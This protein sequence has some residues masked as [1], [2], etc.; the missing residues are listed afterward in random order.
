MHHRKTAFRSAVMLMLAVLTVAA[1]AACGGSSSSSANPNTLLKDTFTGKHTVTSGDIDLTLTIDPSGSSLVNGPITF[2]FG[3][4]FQSRGA[5]KLP[6]SNFTVSASALGH[7]VLVG[8]ISTG[9]AGYVTFQGSSYQLP[10]ASFQKLES[11][12]SQLSTSQGTSS[13]SS[14]LTKLGIHPLNWLTNPTVV[15]TENVGGAQTDHIHAGVN[16]DAMLNDLST[17]LTKSYSLGLAGGTAAKAL[18]GGIPAA[19]RSKIAAEVKNPSVDIW[20]GTSDHT[21]RRLTITLTVPVTGKTSTQLGGVTSADIGL[22]LQ[23]SDLNQP[24]TIKAPTNVKPFSQ[25]QA[26]L[27][28]FVQSL[29]GLMAAGGTGSSGAGTSGGTTTTGS[30]SAGVSRYSQCLQKAGTDIQKV[31]KCASLLSSGG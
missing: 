30:A 16:V 18:S 4:P 19:D 8:V 10:A 13:G 2:T 28:S 5:G 29:S 23:Y 27:N 9:T 22:T 15:G 1:T 6:E 7:N 3:G 26:K 12:F 31:Q 20:T 17:A 21:I 25:F 11:S 24:Q 14:A